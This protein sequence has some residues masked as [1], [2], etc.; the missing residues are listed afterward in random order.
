MEFF[1]AHVRVFAVV[2]A[3][4]L[5]VWQRLTEFQGSGVFMLGSFY[6]VL[7]PC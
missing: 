6:V 7:V 5:L 3:A 1:S 4:A 2:G